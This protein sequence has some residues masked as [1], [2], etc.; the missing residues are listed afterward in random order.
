MVRL[1]GRF[2]FDLGNIWAEVTPSEFEELVAGGLEAERVHR[3]G[4]AAI[5]ATVRSALGTPTTP[6]EMLGEAEDFGDS[7]F[8]DGVKPDP[9]ELYEKKRQRDEEQARAKFAEWVDG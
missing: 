6:E 7:P 9:A 8:L 3:Y 1:C 4:Y 2:G 5:I